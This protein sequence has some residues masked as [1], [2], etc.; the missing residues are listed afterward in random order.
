MPDTILNDNFEDTLWPL[1]RLK[2]LFLL[3]DG[4][5]SPYE[6]AKRAG[7]LTAVTTRRSLAEAAL[8]KAHHD[9][10]SSD[11]WT[12]GEA[13][14]LQPLQLLQNIGA[15]IE[16]D[17]PH[18]APGITMARVDGLQ[19]EAGHA[20]IRMHPTA[21]VSK[22]AVLD[23]SAGPIV[24]D[25]DAQ[26]GALCL[27]R[28]PAY[29]GKQTRLDMCNFSNTIAGTNCR[30]G[31]E[32]AD[33][34]VGDFSNKHHEGFL[35]HSL[36]GDWVNLG[37]LTT[38]SDLKN[39]YGEVRL[40]FGVQKFTS[41]TIKFGAIIGDYAKTAIGT[42]LGTGAI[43]DVGANLFGLVHRSGYF[44]P[45]LWGETKIY[46][47]A[48]FIADTERMMQRRSQILSVP[49]RQLLVGIR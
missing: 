41:G 42:M 4:I 17:L 9:F 11:V 37:A 8:L 46:D 20:A 36:V 10:L 29:I 7:G 25:A 34:I 27:V 21:V 13:S 26:I 48:K 12:H 49:L 5:F 2:P 40:V 38:T 35:G 28:G 47:R 6:R 1:V 14:P 19:V 33:S 45:F 16:A 39:N 30:L 18:F 32:I 23:A 15:N 3:R 24:I 31:G 44:R 43:V 22:Y